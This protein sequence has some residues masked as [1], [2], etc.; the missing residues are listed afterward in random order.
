ML[1]VN[2]ASMP[3]LQDQNGYFFFVYM[4]DNSITSGANPMISRKRSL[5]PEGN[6]L[7]ER[8]SIFFMIIF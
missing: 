6:G 4:I 1:M 8:F 5:Q 7:F 3:Y 2:T